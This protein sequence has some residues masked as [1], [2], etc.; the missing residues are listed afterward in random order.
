MSVLAY[1]RTARLSA[2]TLALLL[3]GAVF[4]LP[5]AMLALAALAG[6]WNGILPGPLTLRHLA[7]LAA[8]AQ[9]EALWHSVATGLLAATAAVLLGT[10]G[11]LAARRLGRGAKRALDALFF[12]PIALPSAAIGLA[13]LVAFSRRPVLLNG[14]VALVVIAHVVLVTAYAYAN[15]E[16]GLA[17]IPQGLEEMADSLGATP[18]LVLRS[19]TLPL[20]APHL[21]AAFAL[22]FALS[23]GEIG[24][25]IM[26]YPPQW[27]TAP[28][29]IFAL[30]DRGQVFAGAA[31][32]VAL[33]AAT[34]CVLV[35]LDRRRHRSTV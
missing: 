23:M 12:L 19:V 35:L 3:F 10:A 4:G 11:A 20:L 32:G 30:T 24:A 15:A 26:L 7:G 27:V 14:T 16:A 17:A 34:F 31:L 6:Q 9:G 2:R 1:T 13:L 33:L 8:G 5:L 29:R 25:T 18:G 22:G 28:V 21:L